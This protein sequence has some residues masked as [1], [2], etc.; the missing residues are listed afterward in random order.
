MPIKEFTLT[1]E[2]K[3]YI[4]EN[5]TGGN[6]Q[7]TEPIVITDDSDD[8]RET[9]PKWLTI[10]ATILY[11]LDKDIL[12]GEG[13]LNDQHIYI[14]QRLIKKQFPNVGGLQPT[15]LQTHMKPLP[16]GSL[17][18]LHT[19]GNHWIALSTFN[20]DAAVITVYDSKYTSVSESTQTILAKMVYTDRPFFSIKMASVSKQSGSSDC[21][22]FAIAYITHIAHELDPSLCVFNQGQMRKHLIQCFEKEELKPFPILKERRSSGVTKVTNCKVYCYCRCP[23]NGEKMVKCNG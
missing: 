4:S 5:I 11:Q 10:N 1:D 6:S 12:L 20:C 23:Y 14:A 15:V 16:T 8:E 19:D 3:Q 17:Q 21:G 7:A 18:I 9:L 22:L 13:W 2:C